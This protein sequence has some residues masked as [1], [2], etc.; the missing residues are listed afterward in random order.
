MVDVT[1][2]HDSFGTVSSN[3]YR[4]W[5]SA[6]NAIVEF[7]SSIWQPI[8]CDSRT[9][10]IRTKWLKENI[11]FSLNCWFFPLNELRLTVRGWETG[12]P[13]VFAIMLIA[14]NINRAS[15]DQSFILKCLKSVFRYF[16]CRKRNSFDG[17]KR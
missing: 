5:N 4:A 2:A 8:H 12:T 9:R 15:A 7:P 16:F 3:G 1:W 6:N 13:N 11:I 17:W 10:K 14:I